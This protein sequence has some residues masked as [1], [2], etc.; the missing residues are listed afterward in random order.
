MSLLLVA[1]ELLALN[2]A[3]FH[4]RL[5]EYRE[6]DKSRVRESQAPTDDGADLA[7]TGDFAVE[8]YWTDTVAAEDKFQL[9]HA[10]TLLIS[11]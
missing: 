5:P 2:V 4:A 1:F 7:T 11:Q 9:K 6:L 3:F 8:E 10:V